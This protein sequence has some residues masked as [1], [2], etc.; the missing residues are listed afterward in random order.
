MITDLVQIRRLGEKKHAENERFRKHLKTREWAE[1]QLRRAAREIQEK[2][3]CRQCAEC[4][5]VTEVEPTRRDIERLSKFLGISTRE[6]IA[7]Y[8]MIAEDKSR[9]LKRS[10]KKGCI[11]LSGNDCT[12]YEARPLDCSG[13]PHLMKGAGSIPAKMWAFVER[14]EFCPIVYNWMEEAKKLTKFR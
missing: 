4:C 14:A 7:K 9:I 11:F 10:E 3:D 1:K 6:F 5:R 13:F 2:F 8:T 12:V